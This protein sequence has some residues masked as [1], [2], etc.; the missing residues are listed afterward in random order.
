MA[1]LSLEIQDAGLGVCSLE[2]L[3]F[4]TGVARACLEAS[5]TGMRSSV[6]CRARSN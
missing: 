6:E 4:V 5:W 2:I 3:V 1:I